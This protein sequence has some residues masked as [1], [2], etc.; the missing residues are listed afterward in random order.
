MKRAIARLLPLLALA[1]FQTADAQTIL[2][3]GGSQCGGDPFAGCF[4]ASLSLT[5]GNTFSLTLTNTG[6]GVFTQI[7][8]G[9]LSTGASETVP[10]FTFTQVGNVSI[11]GS[12]GNTFGNVV[13]INPS[14]LS[15]TGIDRPIIGI[16]AGGNN[17]LTVG[18]TATFSFMITGGTFDISDVQIAVHQQGGAVNANCGGSTKIVF[19]RTTGTSGTMNNSGNALCDTPPGGGGTGNV[20]PEPSTYVLLGSG[21][22]GIVG[23]A[24]RRRRNAV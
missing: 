8:V 6:A 22:L 15:G 14:G 24:A 18:G 9:S 20:V 19:E 16:D 2:T 1:A 11:V 7:G 21:L 3:T 4:N 23:I 17:G 13:Q 12:P 5:G 10:S